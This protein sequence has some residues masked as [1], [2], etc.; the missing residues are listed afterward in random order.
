MGR[1]KIVFIAVS[2]FVCAS[3]VLA[4]FYE[5]GQDP[6]S[7]KWKKA[8]TE[9]FTLVYPSG[10]AE[11]ASRLA[12]LMESSYKANSAQLDHNPR[13]IPLLIHNQT[14][15]SNAFVT[16]AP[17]RMEFFSFPDPANYPIDWLEELSLHEYRHV[18]QIDKVNK[19]FTHFL[20]LLL[21][22]QANGVV[23][24]MMPLWFIEGDAVSAETSLSQSG[25]G[26]LPTF[27]MELKAE[28][29]SG[30][31]N[32]SLS[33]AY[34]GSYRDH[35]PD[36]YELGYQMVSF[37]RKQYGDDYWTNA[38]EYVSRKPYLLSPNYFY[39]RKTTGA[40]MGSMY[41]NTMSYISDHWTTAYE[42]RMPDTLP[43]LN[44]R[45]SKIY[46]SYIN[47]V[48]W[49]DSSILALKSGLD[50]I[51]RFVKINPEGKEETVFIPGSL[52]SQRFSVSHGKI[53]WDE[54]VQDSRW[55]N[56]SFSVIKEYN[57]K[58]G[59]IRKLSR[60]SKYLSPSYSITGDS[61]VA[62]HA[63]ENYR[64]SLVLLDGSDGKLLRE[65]PSPE[66]QYLMFPEWLPSGNKIVVISSG[67]NG[68]KILQYD[69]SNPGWTELFDAGFVNIDQLK[70]SG[71]YIYFSGGFDGTD[72]IY[73]LRVS[74]KS[75]RKITN[76]AFGA[77]YPEILENRL[78]YASY[79]KNGYDIIATSFNP[80]EE[81]IFQ[82]PDTIRE[83]TF[84]SVDLKYDSSED[85]DRASE[86]I[87]IEEK[88]YNRLSHLFNLHSW[89][90]YWFDYNN[91]NIHNP[92]VSP[93]ITLL[94]QNLLSTAFTSLGY[95]RK[96]GENYFH[97]QFTYKG[98]LPVIDFSA[99]YGGAPLVAV[100]K[101]EPLPVTQTNLF[102]TLSS[103]IPLTLS[104]GKIVS[105]IRPSLQLTYNSTYYFNYT[106]SA[107]E[108]GVEFLQSGIYLYSYQRTAA[109]DLQPKL[110]ITL[111]ANITNTP[112]END[113]YGNISSAKM[114]IYFPG[115]FKN[116]GLRFRGEWQNQDVKAY[117]FQNKLSLPRGYPQ[118][119]FI[120]MNKISADYVLPVVYPDLTLG[121]IIYLKRIRADLFIDYMKGVE[122]YVLSGSEVVT[123]PPEYPVSQG[124]EVMADY[125]IFRFIFEF[126]TGF[127]FVNMPHIDTYGVQLLFSVNI[128]NF[129]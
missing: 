60:K 46:A 31:K 12:T 82:M 9:H 115:I 76:S 93:G 45:K 72:Q 56:R 78:A 69:L 22:Q 97:G 1:I 103:Y 41:R 30:K 53:V 99:D 68:K 80:S 59:K 91:P 48:F 62:V 42:K 107:Y 39:A 117:Y 75:L 121:S 37:A 101:D 88:P 4:Q 27:E 16:W 3:P 63:A 128:D 94:S 58:T 113:L 23:A 28:L 100:V 126:S 118:R 64:F 120:S 50:I 18:V 116:H 106:Q 52:V 11:N 73:S 92:E 95:E 19:H 65:I 7:L 77:F 17:K 5:F 57:S 98:F 84:S 8:E 15:Y 47:P 20:T 89:A 43:G 111:D 122:K 71:G 6:S 32:Y 10:F 129:L 119:L 85:G 29:L 61:I 125:H 14:V 40:G 36:R 13:K 54:Y 25:R 74:D 96:N 114:N 112:F 21:G 127:R 86:S 70:A 87:N 49:D 67:S 108:R 38:L 44:V 109:R 104:S 24:G 124:V 102:Y 83:Q 34:L 55:T 51:P 66:N 81:E 26:R 79:G 105:G 2:F 35:V 110:G 90:P 123:T 33:K